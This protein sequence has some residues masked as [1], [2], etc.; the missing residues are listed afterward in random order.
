M[1]RKKVKTFFIAKRVVRERRIAG[2][3]VLFEKK[4]CPSLITIIS[5]LTKITITI[6]IFYN[7]SGSKR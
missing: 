7:D 5:I 1:T 6:I 3:T 2:L 4:K